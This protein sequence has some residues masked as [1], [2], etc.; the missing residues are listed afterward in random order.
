MGPVL[1]AHCMNKKIK[2]KWPKEGFGNFREAPLFVRQTIDE[3]LEV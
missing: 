2:V 1:A 3:I